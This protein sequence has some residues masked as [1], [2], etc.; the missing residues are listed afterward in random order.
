MRPNPGWHDLE[1]ELGEEAAESDAHKTD[2]QMTA[3]RNESLSKRKGI[4][5]AIRNLFSSKSLGFAA[6]EGKRGKETDSFTTEKLGRHATLSFPLDAQ[7]QVR[8]HDAW[9]KLGEMLD[10]QD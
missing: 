9:H 4:V 1:K 10:K 6:V 5:A 8:H 7:G 2:V 3:R